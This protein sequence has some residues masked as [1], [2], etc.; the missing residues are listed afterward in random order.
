MVGNPIENIQL[1]H[2]DVTQH[3]L[4][5]MSVLQFDLAIARAENEKL[6]KLLNDSP[7]NNNPQ[8]LGN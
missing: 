3:L 7:K 4:K 2:E 6:K 8:P 1:T 5:Q